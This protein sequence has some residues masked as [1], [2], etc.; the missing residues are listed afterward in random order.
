M[1]RGTI[2]TYQVAEA[3]NTN[4]LVKII[5]RVALLAQA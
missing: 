2:S 4:Q 5:Q 3:Q 1:Q